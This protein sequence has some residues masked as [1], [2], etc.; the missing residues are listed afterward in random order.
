[1]LLHSWN[2]RRTHEFFHDKSYPEPEVLARVFGALRATPVPPEALSRSLQLDAEAVSTALEKLW[3]H[4]GARFVAEGGQQLVS[5][6]QDGWRSPYLRQRDHRREQLDDMQRFAD[7]HTCRMAALVR[8]FGDQEDA[9]KPCGVC[10]VC[11]PERC[12]VRA[13]REPR[14][15]ESAAARALVESLRRRD[16]QATG[17]LYAEC[18]GKDLERRDFEEVLGGMVR[19]GLLRVTAET[20][21]KDG[22]TIAFQRAWLGPRARAAGGPVLEFTV[23]AEAGAA[24]GATRAGKGRKARAAGRA[25]AG[26]ADAELVARLKDWRL[27]ESRKVGVPAFRVL[28]DRTLL[29]IAAARPRDEEGLLAVTG[30]GPGLFKRYGSALLD[31]C[32]R[33]T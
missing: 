4:G 6:G 13:A 12:L 21:E 7:G 18:G 8:H 3:I 10:D 24:P 32:R 25:A 28:H 22:K 5:R 2:D 9:G 29:G 1:V 26:A 17:R 30:F 19:A 16:G 27:S 23:S 11:A 20:F 31:L 33:P 14:P 15:S